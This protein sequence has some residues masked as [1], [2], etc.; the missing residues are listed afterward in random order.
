MI[1]FHEKTPIEKLGK[2]RGNC[3]VFIWS[4]GEYDR[5]EIFFVLLNGHDAKT[6]IE[7]WFNEFDPAGVT[8]IAYFSIRG[9]V[10]LPVETQSVTR[11]GFKE[12]TK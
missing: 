10:K 6:G 9:D 4:E 7:S 1:E 5:Y 3:E 8:P 12:Q 11:L 2:A